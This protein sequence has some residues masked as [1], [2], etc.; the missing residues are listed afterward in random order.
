MEKL[1]FLEND[2]FLRV[3]RFELGTQNPC[4]AVDAK[5]EVT[6][7]ATLVSLRRFSC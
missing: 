7:G 4:P 5:C 6:G 3:V 1:T 2:L